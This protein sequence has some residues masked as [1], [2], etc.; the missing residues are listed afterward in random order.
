[1]PNNGQVG[2]QPR[3]TPAERRAFFELQRRLVELE[4]G[5]GGGEPG[6]PGPA[7]PT[8]PA[9]S[10]GPAGPTGPAGAAGS[11][12]LNGA[13]QPDPGF[14]VTGDY[15]TDTTNG[16]LYGPKS[17]TG[18]GVQ[19][20]PTISGASST[21]TGTFD[22][23]GARYRFL[24]AGRVLGCRYHR[25]NTAVA[26]L[27]VKAW[28][29]STQIKTAEIV[30]NQGVVTGFFTVTFPTPV[31]VAADETWTFTMAATGTGALP[32]TST[33]QT[34]ADT[35]DVTFIEY[36][37]IGTF[38]VYPASIATNIHHVEPIYE[39]NE[40]WPPTLR[41]VDSARTLTTPPTAFAPLTPT[42]GWG[43]P[44]GY[45]VL[46]WRRDP[47]GVIRVRGSLER[48]GG[49]LVGPL[50]TLVATLPSG[51]RPSSGSHV[52]ATNSAGSALRAIVG[53]D[54]TLNVQNITGQTIATNA[55]VS[56]DMVTFAT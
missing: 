6:P 13:G 9:G 8:G 4:E 23:V 27:T 31:V 22:E 20:R 2:Y 48:T 10:T 16:I 43:T 47:G 14:G 35:A 41:Y 44:S 17:A 54:G 46:G 1:M 18:W 55:I 11:L 19:Q 39:P 21:A 40:A 3:N 12:L 25:N 49:N 50:T 28:K 24:R 45:A 52:Y 7:G 30:D 51:S 56:F 36:R 15:Y 53:T 37:N 26:S 32:Y 5:G 29:D 42:A 33:A 38:N 34:V